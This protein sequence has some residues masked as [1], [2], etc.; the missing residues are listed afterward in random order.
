MARKA[1]VCMNIM[2]KQMKEKPFSIISKG[3][4]RQCN[5]FS[6]I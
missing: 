3:E 6:V 5:G 1:D 2:I 4:P